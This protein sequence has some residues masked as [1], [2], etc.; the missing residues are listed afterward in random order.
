[1][2]GLHRWFVAAA[3]LA[4]STGLARAQV[5]VKTGPAN[6]PLTCSAYAAGTPELRPEGYTEPAGNI[7]I[8]CSGGPLAQIG[9][10]IPTVNIVVYV[11]P[12]VPITSRI[13]GPDNASEA[14]L[15]IDEPGA[16]I[17]TGAT[18]GYGPDAAQSLCTTAQ[19]QNPA[20]SPC[21][22]Y[23]STDRSGQYQ[24]AVE[25]GTSTPAQN[26]YQGKIGDFGVNSV[27]FYNVPV[28]P[29]AYQGVTRVFRITNIRIP[30][31][32]WNSSQG[33]QFALSTSP[34]ETLPLI[35]SGPAFIGVVGPAMTAGVNPAPAGGQSPF[36][37]CVP[38]ASPA[39]TAT[40]AFTEGFATAF[41]TRVVAGGVSNGYPGNNTG[42]TT[43]AAEAQNLA[44]PINQNIPGGLYAGFAFSNE[45]GFILPAA[46]TTVSGIAYTAGL[47]D[48]GTRL[49]AVFTNIPAGVTLYV[50]TASAASYT[51][52]G[53]T[54]TAPYAVLVAGSQRDEANNDGAMFAPLQS[55][56][57]G[58]DGLSA[59]PLTPDISGTAAAIWEVVDSN[60]ANVD[61]LTFSVYVAYGSTPGT[62]NPASVALSFAPEP[63]GGSFTTA[64]ATQALTSPVPRFA[65]LQPQQGSWGTINSCP[66]TV[67]GP[68]P[69]SFSYSIG[70]S[71]PP[72]Q[73]RPVTISP[74]N[75]AV[76]VTPLVT[77]PPGG[78]WLSA[79]L[80]GGILTIST[81]PAGLAA[82]STAYSGN[83][84]LS[85]QGVAGVLVP[86]TLTVFPQAALSIDK[87]HA[88]NFIQGQPR[89]TYTI[90]VGNSAAAG[91]TSGTVTVTD[92]LPGDGSLA[93][94]SMTGDGWTCGAGS[95]TRSD[96]LPGGSVY[97]SIAVTVS[98]AENAPSEVTN[99][100]TV[101]GGGSLPAT[102]ASDQTSIVAL[103][104]TVTGDRAASVADVQSMINQALGSV[105]PV[106]D[107]NSD[108]SVNV[109][110]VQIVIDA[111]L[112]QGCV[113]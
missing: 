14:M 58:S 82:S 101:S 21:Q 42:N 28:L 31:P 17:T 92:V 34:S 84:K 12:S 26:V 69:V 8:E 68:F 91:P 63:G 102:P 67:G 54:N 10:A 16:L 81:N 15:T 80:S 1:M 29:P 88:G 23:V 59:Y 45:S 40:T 38:Q 53:G 36:T 71:A 75:L 106:Y 3:I 35:P 18:G 44:G 43:W 55:T 30:A 108:G 56:I 70:G 103:T 94:V 11:S 13:I 65:I 24:V 95:C 46:S 6:S 27:A 112:G 66:V 20:G 99:Q 50:S 7:V 90:T 37:A 107:L 64:E 97:S 52:P 104:C 87:T 79:S 61:S 109:A 5:G 62:V 85:A 111:V 73:T 57:T 105:P 47:A 60:P 25:P 32:G 19:Q 22:A 77:T 49:K 48:F 9:A 33:F 113:L 110:D 96:S 4:L 72:S 74:P 39:L 98:V 76:T 41:K 89:A 86:V 93:L 51:I 78:T 100:A 83:V 2:A